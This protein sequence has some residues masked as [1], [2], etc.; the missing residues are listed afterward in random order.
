MDR[1]IVLRLERPYDTEEEFL[2]VESWTIAQRSIL[3]VDEAERP[4]GTVVRCE[5]ALRGGHALIVAEG[6][7]SKRLPPRD[8]RPGGLVVRLKRLSAASS[9]FIAR[10]LAARKSA[11]DSGPGTSPESSQLTDTPPTV[12]ARTERGADSSRPSGPVS[13][14]TTRASVVPRASRRPPAASSGSAA[15]SAEGLDPGSKPTGQRLDGVGKELPNGRSEVLA[16]LHAL[17]KPGA[18]PGPSDRD[19]V[20]SRLRSRQV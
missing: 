8:N 3:L 12:A 17:A 11:E 18:T 16:R 20:L 2:R 7:V 15:Q 19:R 10:A 13:S 4:A 6:E 1:P 9:A 5:L 14:G